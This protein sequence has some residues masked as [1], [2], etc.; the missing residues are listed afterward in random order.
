M[1][2]W[3]CVSQSLAFS[4]CLSCALW[5]AAQWASTRRDTF[6]EDIC[7]VLGRLHTF[8]RS[9]PRR[10]GED[11]LELA[12][13]PS[14][15]QFLQ[16]EKEALGSGCVA[17]VYKG[18]ML[19]GEYSGRPVAVKIV[20][21]GLKK[22]VELDLSLMRGAAK[23]LEL[24]LPRVRWLSIP[25]TINEFGQLMESQLDLRREAVNLERFAH[26]FE[27]DRTLVFPRPLY[28]WV[29]STVL[30]EEFKEGVPV[31]EYF[32]GSE[33]KQLA[34]MGLQ[35]FLKM[36][37]LNNFVHGDL[38]PGNMMVGRREDGEGPCL[39]MLDAGIVCELD[40]HDRKN[41]VDVFYAIVVGD[42]KLAGR[43]MIERVRTRNHQQS[44]NMGVGKLSRGSRQGVLERRLLTQMLSNICAVM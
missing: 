2:C 17:Q 23:L 33:T 13:G 30:V 3:I 29:S 32:G 4:L 40:Q 34:R 19:A 38:H 5:K 7:S 9:R 20:D 6:P 28:P 24:V 25:E 15:R 11:A 36:V 43:L 8:T 21:P 35:A 1:S 27:H 39:V 41:F 10:Y 14:W 26:D 16:L 22:A 42:G 12:F 18:H 37:F 31:S 44:R